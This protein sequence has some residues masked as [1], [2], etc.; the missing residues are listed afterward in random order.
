MKIALTGAMGCGKS[1]AL[2]AFR[3][4]GAKVLD[5][6]KLAHTALE[7]NPTVIEK[8]KQLFGD[9]IYEAN[10]KPN[11]VN[12]AKQ[13][14]SDSQKLEKLEK[15][16]HPTIK[17]IWEDKNLS[18]DN[19]VVEVPLLF[20]KKLEKDFDICVSV[21]CSEALRLK[22]LLQR[23]MNPEEI[24]KRDAFQLSAQEKA[25]LADIVLFN[26]G[27]LDF[28]NRQAAFILSRLNHK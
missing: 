10:G 8:I 17:K 15:I 28:L 25:K 20:E 7:T 6:D 24:S 14:F 9:N 19:I 5:A 11:R 12:I 22:R 13:V 18:E 1:A 23:G 2:D 26:E 16:I 3:L 21:L 27:N 4:A